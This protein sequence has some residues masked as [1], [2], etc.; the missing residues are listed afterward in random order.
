MWNRK[1]YADYM[2]AKKYIEDSLDDIWKELKRI[3]IAVIIVVIAVSFKKLIKKI[4]SQS[5][6]K[7]IGN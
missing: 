2:D 1:K 3:K 5:M 6:V 4:R 7:N